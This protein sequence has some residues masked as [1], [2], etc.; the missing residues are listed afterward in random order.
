M[1][2]LS[3]LRPSL[4]LRLGLGAQMLAVAVTLLA[5]RLLWASDGS[6]L[7]DSGWRLLQLSLSWV[8][9]IVVFT[10]MIAR[11]MTQSAGE[12]WRRE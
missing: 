2:L 10:A 3:R 12:G 11:R 4:L 6:T 9:L 8:G 1:P 5:P 7:G